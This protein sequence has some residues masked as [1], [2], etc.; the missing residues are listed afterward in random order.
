M[1]STTLRVEEDLW[2]K[3]RKWALADN[4][5]ANEIVVQAI[6][7]WVAKTEWSEDD[8]TKPKSDP[9]SDKTVDK[10][11]A[12]EK[13]RSSAPGLV[14]ASSLVPN[15]EEAAGEKPREEV[16]KAVPERA[17]SKWRCKAS[18]LSIG[19]CTYPR[20]DLRC[21]YYGKDDL[22]WMEVPT[23]VAGP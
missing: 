11:K 13:A 14:L 23:P 15:L 5:S 8:D 20:H 1:V 18:P 12:Y 9:T 6:R 17:K 19:G 4:K 22:G 21:R 10:P 2:E 16:L 3:V 7:D